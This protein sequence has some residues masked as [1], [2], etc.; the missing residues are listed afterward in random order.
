MPD[1]QIYY[2]VP[3]NPGYVFDPVAS[4][5][6]G[7]QTFRKNPQLAITAQQEEQDRIKE[8]QE[9]EAFN[10]SP[11]GQL[12]P[13][14]GSTA[15]LIAASQ[16]MTPAADPVSAAI[17]AQIQQQTAAQAAAQGATQVA[18]PNV[19][20]ATAS[21]GV[22]TGAG[23]GS[24]VGGGF[25]GG[26]AGAEAA[27]PTILGNA[28]G[29][30]VL[31]LAGIAAG[32]YL[33]GKSA[34]DLIQGNKDN[35]I[36]GKIG[37]GTLAVA[38]GGI[39]EL[40]RASGI[41]GGKS[42]KEIEAG[43]WGAVGKEGAMPEGYDYFSGTGGEK[44]RDEKFLTPDAIRMNPDNYNNVP[45]WD[46]WDKISQDRFLSTLLKEGKVQ[47]KKGGI[48]YDDDRAKSLAEEIRKSST[49]ASS[50]AQ[51]AMQSTKLPTQEQVATSSLGGW[52]NQKLG[53]APFVQL[54]DPLLKANGLSLNTP[55]A[56]DKMFIVGRD[57]AAPPIVNTPAQA[58]ALEAMRRSSTLSPGIGKDGKP[59]I[60]RR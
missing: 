13:V 24:A 25:G 42:T 19:I 1:G 44:S 60:Y 14:V 7:R 49:P 26:A 47:E 58:A 10:R 31:P 2:E 29:M 48:Y 5:A 45:D 39:S 3:G 32:T 40:A 33:G 53:A 11:T 56:N 30:G 46:S 16:L 36:P 8:A 51:S 28:A 34:Y 57:G 50:A 41:F 37:R 23:G 54:S 21:P 43:R 52:A 17:A 9:Q 12:L 15:G 4:R 18:T 22:T 27:S 38:T 55:P 35:S 20:G 6:S 59:I